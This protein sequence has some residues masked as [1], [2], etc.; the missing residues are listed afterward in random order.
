MLPDN[1]IRQSTI[2][3]LKPEPRSKDEWT[4]DVIAA[5]EL[6]RNIRQIVNR[7]FQNDVDCT[8]WGCIDG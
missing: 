5:D 8:W 1:T 2:V 3:H 6:H 4:I 7:K